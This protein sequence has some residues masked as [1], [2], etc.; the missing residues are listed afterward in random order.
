MCVARLESPFVWLFDL[1]TLQALFGRRWRSRRTLFGDQSRT[2]PDHSTFRN[3]KPEIRNQR[4][5][6]T[7]ACV[8]FSIGRAVVLCCVVLCPL[9]QSRKQFRLSQCR[10]ILEANEQIDPS[11]ISQIANFLRSGRIVDSL[12]LRHLSQSSFSCPPSS[13]FAADLN[14]TSQPIVTQNSKFFESLCFLS[15]CH[16]LPWP[17]ARLFSAFPPFHFMA[18]SLTL[19]TSPPPS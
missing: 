19:P 5:I 8:T 14:Q 18:F 7:V 9:R 2:R 3:Q 10:T 11:A 13:H 16:S 4:T 15:I 12:S 1:Q 6:A 17:R